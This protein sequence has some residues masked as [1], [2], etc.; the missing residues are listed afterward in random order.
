MEKIYTFSEIKLATESQNDSMTRLVI[1][2][3]LNDK[4]VKA[5]YPVNREEVVSIDH[6]QLDK[7]FYV[8]A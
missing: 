4:A 3:M 7:Y 1:I 8:E 5:L 6:N 2:S